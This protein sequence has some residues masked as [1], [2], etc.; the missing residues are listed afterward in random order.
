MEITL[1]SHRPG[2]F[3]N[4]LTAPRLRE[5]DEPEHSNCGECPGKEEEVCESCNGGK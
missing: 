5:E 1:K 3:V 2:G 4:F